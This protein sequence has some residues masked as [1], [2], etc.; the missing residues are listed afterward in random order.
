MA[1]PLWA[2]SATTVADMLSAG[3][4]SPLEALDAVAGRVAAVNPAVNALPTLCLDRAASHA[5][6]L[7][8][9][10]PE[11][12][13]VLAGLPVPIKDSYE[14]EGV[15]TTWGSL[16]YADHIATR[17]DY[18]VEAV[19]AAGGIVFAKSNTPEFEAG[20]NT[21]N[22]VFGRTLN[23]FDLTRSAA[24][25]SGGAAAAVATGMAWIAQGSDFACSLR[26]P[27]SFCNVVG[28]RPSPGIVPQGPSALPFQVLSVLG[29]I[30]RNV[31]DAA[32]GLDAMA[33]FDP[34]DPLSRRPL[35]IPYRA[36]A[37]NPRRAK[38][39]AA[40]I[41]LGITRVGADVR[42]TVGTALERLGAAGLDLV[43]EA[44]DLT[45]CHAAFRPLR[46]FQF[47]ALRANAL[48]DHRDKLKPEVVWNIEQGM[49]LTAA[50]LAG[51]EAARATV[52]D[53][54]LAFLDRHEFLIAPTAPV[55][56]YP[57]EKRFVDEIDGEKMETYLDWLTLGYAITVTGCPAISIPCGLSR[58]GLP[59]GLQIVGRPYGEASLFS[60]AAWCEDA[61]GASLR[62]PVDPRSP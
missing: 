48:R 39:A 18:M 6:R 41:D 10:K 30:A 21:F 43:D 46:A 55:P 25:S 52:R 60:F 29:P 27:A 12:R 31:S 33:R 57:V 34:R 13:G 11:D 51:A 14:V 49:K 47:A 20:A 7:G 40:S 3:E 26:Y 37:E 24:G 62:R 44:P 5:A 42:A 19:E 1:E 23:P 8:E 53:A 58:E 56:P 15:R 4:V 59:V 22:E 61:L 9:R 2:L 35:A 54:M 32:L 38:R 50:D 28:L 17:S 36:A 45:L 16:A